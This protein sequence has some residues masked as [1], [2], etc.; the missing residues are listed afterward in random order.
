VEIYNSG[1]STLALGDIMLGDEEDLGGG[2]GM[3]QF[4]P[5]AFLAP[6]QVAVIANSAAAFMAN[7]GFQPDYEIAGTDS[8]VADLLPVRDWANGAMNLSNNGDEVLLPLCSACAGRLQHRT[9]T[10]LPGHR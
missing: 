3:L 5:Q 7:Y 8:G 9:Q 10:R 2:E 6:H 1:D 4:P